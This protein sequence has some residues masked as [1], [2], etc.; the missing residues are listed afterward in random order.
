MALVPHRPVLILGAGVNGSAVARELA[1][2]GVP[3]WLVDKADIA[4]G[5]TAGSSRLI[6]GGLRYLEYGDIQLVRESLEERER[7]LRLAPQFVKPLALHIPVRRWSGGLLQSAYRFLQLDRFAFARWLEARLPHSSGRGLFV[8]RSGLR[9]YDWLA[10]SET[11]PGHEVH[12][13]GDADMPAVDPSQYRWLCT[14]YDAQMLYPERFVLALL[15]DA[16]AAAAQHGGELHICPHHRA[17]FHGGRVRIIRG[18]DA[19]LV[20]EFEPSAIVNA[21]GAWGDLTLTSLDI[22]A[23]RLLGG[24]KG[25]HILTDHSGLKAAL[26][27]AGVYAEAADGRLAFLLPLAGHVLVGTTDIRFPESPDTAIAD[28]D[29]VA[30]LVGLVNEV[31]GHLKLTTGD[32]FAHYCGV[33][34]LPFVPSGRTGSIPRGHW[35]DERHHEGCPLLTLIGGK[36]TTWRAFAEEVADRLFEQ[37][38]YERHESTRDR[39]IPGASG[40]PGEAEQALDA[41][42]HQL[43]VDTG[44]TK[45]QVAAIVPLVGSHA[46]QVLADARDGDRSSLAGTTIPRAFVDWS[47]R[48]EWG[49]RLADVVIRRLMLGLQPNL[50]RCTLFDVAD[51]LVRQGQL[52][53]GDL[54]SAVQECITELR[55]RHGMD[56]AS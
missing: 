44:F 3:V 2:N 40:Y 8:V 16:Q 34:P 10:R 9:M 19:A 51:R 39:E 21:T 1:I 46:A 23:P 13:I 49:S 25:S 20:H 18:R 52:D 41:W 6:H 38:G 22:T 32:V 54:E 31:F 14:Y 15:A 53:A 11:L 50:R 26:G 24:T 28:S 12:R 43:A 27:H 33:R 17:E 5:A 42:C 47:I 4:T 7:L 37:Q 45:E 48:H 29:E 30:Y 55:I 35:I 36:L 56:V